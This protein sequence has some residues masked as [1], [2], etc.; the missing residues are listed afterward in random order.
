MHKSRKKKKYIALSP[1]LCPV[2]EYLSREVKPS[3]KVMPTCVKAKCK[4]V[5]KRIYYFKVNKAV[6]N[7]EMRIKG[8]NPYL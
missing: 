6:A 1:V 7:A 8:I 4:R 5:Y 2:C 3:N